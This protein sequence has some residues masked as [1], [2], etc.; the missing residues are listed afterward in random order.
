[1]ARIM[2]KGV[3]L[4]FAKDLWEPTSLMGSKE[5][6]RCSPMVDKGS[7]NDKVLWA[8]AR[9]VIA[10]KWGEKKADAILAQIKGNS[11]KFCIKDG[12][13]TDYESAEGRWLVSLSNEDQPTMLTRTR[14]PATKEQIYSG[15][16]VN[17]S[18]DIYAYEFEGA[19]GVAGGIRGVQFVEHGTRLS[20]GGVAGEDDFDDLGGLEGEDNAADDFS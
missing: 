15:A 4:G 9:Q 7:E 16:V 10:E 12:D 17:V 6:Y 8:A 14:A 19:K 11:N 5:K 2:L 18:A 13:A 20:G 3:V 1:M